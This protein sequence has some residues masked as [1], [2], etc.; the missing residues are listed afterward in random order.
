MLIR[1]NSEAIDCA[2][3]SSINLLKYIHNIK[4]KNLDA[5]ASSLDIHTFPLGQTRKLTLIDG[6]P[7]NKLLHSPDPDDV[8][9]EKI[10]LSNSDSFKIKNLVS[11]VYSLTQ[12]PY[13]ILD[14][15]QISISV[16]D[17]LKKFKKFVDVI[18]AP[19]FASQSSISLKIYGCGT[20]NHDL[21]IKTFSESVIEVIDPLDPF[22]ELKYD[23]NNFIDFL[24]E[25]KYFYISFNF[26][27]LRNLPLNVN[28]K[29]IVFKKNHFKLRTYKINFYNPKNVSYLI[30]KS[31]KPYIRLIKT[32]SFEDMGKDLFKKS[33]FN[34]TNLEMKSAVNKS[35]LYVTMENKDDDHAAELEVLSDSQF[36]ITEMNMIEI[37]PSFKTFKTPPGSEEVCA[38]IFISPQF[39]E[40]KKCVLYLLNSKARVSVDSRVT[41]KIDKYFNN[42]LLSSLVTNNPYLVFNSAEANRFIITIEKP[43]HLREIESSLGQ[44]NISNLSSLDYTFFYDIKLY[45]YGVIKDI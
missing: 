18:V 5:N 36:A 31:S 10:I 35:V 17:N 45:R 24:A 44:K 12:N 33:L 23:N 26:D 15:E 32:R 7:N 29:S 40:Y 6:R 30:Y 14:L 9:L 28:R 4:L 8:L 38:E 43:Q 3:V 42:F 16:I 41:F 13:M 27:K 22:N 11:M 34:N 21:A 2:L 25:Y 39:H 19:S 1:Q 20:E 37:Q